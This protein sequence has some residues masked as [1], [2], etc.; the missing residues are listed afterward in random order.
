MNVILNE[1]VK[2]EDKIVIKYYNLERKVAYRLKFGKWVKGEK[3]PCT[4]VKMRFDP[5]Y[6]K[7]I[8]PDNITWYKKELTKLGVMI[9]AGPVPS[10]I[11]NEHS[12]ILKILNFLNNYEL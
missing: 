2:E 9:K 5:E 1:R 11:T 3:M 4:E 7:S 12:R 10:E 8:L 6:V